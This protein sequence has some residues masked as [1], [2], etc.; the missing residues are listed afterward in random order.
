MR[1]FLLCGLFAMSMA[2]AEKLPESTIQRLAPK[3]KAGCLRAP[4][5]P[6]FTEQM[7]A[8]ACSCSERNYVTM[9]RSS[10]FSS[11]NQPNKEDLDRLG[12]VEEKAVA[13]CVMPIAQRNLQKDA[14]A[15]C[16]TSPRSFAPL[17]KLPAAKLKPVCSC[18]AEQFSKTADIMEAGRAQNQEMVK[19]KLGALWLKTL[20]ACIR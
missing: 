7:R 15:N 13:E 16:L 14:L 18:A 6:D 9:L 3:V 10:N 11:A 12:A 17:Q 1:L 20:E 2:Q 4:T 5:S 8:E 19:K